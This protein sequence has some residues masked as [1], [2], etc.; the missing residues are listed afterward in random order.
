MASHH[1]AARRI[2]P[3]LGSSALKRR[4]PLPG[5]AQP[6]RFRAR[7]GDGMD[8][9]PGHAIFPI[10]TQRADHT[11]V[12]IGTGFF[13]AEN[14]VFLTAAHVITAILDERRKP[15]GPFGLFQFLP[16]GTYYIRPIHRAA[17]HVVAD[18]GIGVAQPMHHKTTRAPMPNKV[19][20]LAPEPPPLGTPVCTYAYPKTTVA[21]SAPQV[22]HF[23]PAFFEGLLM[24]RYAEGRDKVILP[25]PCFRT[26]M[27]IHGGA[28]GGPVFGQNGAVFAINSTG[29][30]DED[31]SYVTPISHALDL[32]ITDVRLPGDEHPRSTTLRELLERGFAA[33]G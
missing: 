33:K 10:V 23:Q 13:V 20:T 21:G 9:D 16:G 7:T 17:R 27:V 25:G 14:G 5:Q 32:A 11:F 18:I 3:P 30:E 2:L 8:A 22:V 6:N 19:L 28:S 26:S 29:F 31:V 12:P 1:D 24:E 15:K 4:R